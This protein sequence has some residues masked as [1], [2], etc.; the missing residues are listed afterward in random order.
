LES[1]KAREEKRKARELRAGKEVERR[2][3]NFR[4]ESP[5]AYIHRRI[6]EGAAY[7]NIAAGL[8]KD[9]PRPNPHAE[10]NV[11]HQSEWDVKAIIIMDCYYYPVKGW[12]PG[13]QRK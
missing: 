10:W 11:L 1:C 13:W 7:V 12:P 8:K 9:Y 5:E 6:R 4:K 2:L 3:S